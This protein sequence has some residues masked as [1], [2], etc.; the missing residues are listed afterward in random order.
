MI[1]EFPV[2]KIIEKNFNQKSFGTLEEVKISIFKENPKSKYGQD[3]GS[4][5]N[6][7]TLSDKISADKTA[8]NL[9]CW[10]KF[11]PP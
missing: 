3:R 5:I 1:I 11:C 4:S 2:S 8:E 10:R 9:T 6:D 7:D